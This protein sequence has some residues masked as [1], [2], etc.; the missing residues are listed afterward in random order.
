LHDGTQRHGVQ[1]LCVPAFALTLSRRAVWRRSWKM[2]HS[3]PLSLAARGLVKLVVWRGE[4][5]LLS[6]WK[7]HLCHL[8]GAA[9]PHL[10]HLA[11]PPNPLTGG[12]SMA[13]RTREPPRVTRGAGWEHSW[14][15][16]RSPHHCSS[17]FS[18]CPSL[19]AWHDAR[20]KF[21]T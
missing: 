14:Q 18:S 10:L 12:R 7:G 3:L 19:S 2:L 15:G 5:G 17:D 4:E 6:F 1:L 21:V 11:A 20:L 16:D 9:S 13:T 8:C